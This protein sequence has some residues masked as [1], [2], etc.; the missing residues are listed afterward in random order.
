MRRILTF[1]NPRNVCYQ[2]L[3]NTVP[4]MAKSAFNTGNT[5]KPNL[6]IPLL[7]RGDNEPCLQ[8][9]WNHAFEFWMPSFY[10]KKIYDLNYDASVY[11]IHNA[12]TDIL[13][14]GSRFDR[15]L[16]RRLTFTE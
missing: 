10:P 12:N 3:S 11:V 7:S 14:F 16:T 15:L 2:N 1:H 13:R 6:K 9:L 5:P 4:H 8:F